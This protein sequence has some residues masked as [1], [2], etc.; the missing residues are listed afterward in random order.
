M[1]GYFLHWPFKHYLDGL[2]SH[3]SRSELPFSLKMVPFGQS[4]LDATFS[5]LLMVV[6]ITFCSIILV[7]FICDGLSMMVDSF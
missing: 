2:F 4:N 5:I 6:M 7:A 1:F 3:V